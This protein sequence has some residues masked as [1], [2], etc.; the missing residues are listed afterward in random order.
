MRNGPQMRESTVKS[1]NWK[2]YVGAEHS[3]CVVAGD[4]GR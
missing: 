4:G 3:E 1:G 2:S